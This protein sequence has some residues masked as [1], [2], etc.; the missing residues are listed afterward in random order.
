MTETPGPN[1][2]VMITSDEQRADR[3]GFEAWQAKTPFSHSIPRLHNS[4][5][6]A[7]RSPGLRWATL[8]D[9]IFNLMLSQPPTHTP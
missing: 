7:P 4:A 2:I 5:G 8:A 3:Y 6:F 1:N 9:H